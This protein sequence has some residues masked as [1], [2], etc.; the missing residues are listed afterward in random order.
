ML[1][2]SLMTPLFILICALQVHGSNQCIKLFEQKDEVPDSVIALKLKFLEESLSENQKQMILQRETVALEVL[3]KLFVSQ[4]EINSEVT[5]WV[6][7][8]KEKKLSVL[9]HSALSSI[10]R[11]K[12]LNDLLVDSPTPEIEQLQTDLEGILQKSWRNLTNEDKT[13]NFGDRLPKSLLKYENSRTIAFEE[14]SFEGTDRDRRVGYKQ[15]F[16]VGG[17]VKTIAVPTLILISAAFSITSAKVLAGLFVGISIVTSVTE[18]FNHKYI[19]HSS[20]FSAFN[21]VKTEKLKKVADRFKHLFKYQELGYLGHQKVHHR[22]FSSR[23]V[24]KGPDGKITTEPGKYTEMFSSEEH[25]KYVESEAIR[26]GLD[27][28][29]VRAEKYGVTIDPQGR[30]A[31][32]ASCLPL[33]LAIALLTGFDPVFNGAVF[34]GGLLFQFNSADMHPYLHKTRDNALKEAGPL[35]SLYLRTRWLEASARGHWLHHKN[36]D[37][38]YNITPFSFGDFLF[39]TLQKPDLAQFLMMRDEKIIGAY[40]DADQNN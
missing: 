19:G 11:S 14:A 24:L 9:E 40:W 38:N 15:Y 16:T 32:I 36:A 22:T 21:N 6:S 28:D 31:F 10:Y 2:K 26:E 27:I 3:T 17:V 20:I 37:V 23:S 12:I 30:M 5:N 13:S 4:R 29:R 7:F 18:V 25:K 34:L 1:V 33:E 39:G 35:M 8:L